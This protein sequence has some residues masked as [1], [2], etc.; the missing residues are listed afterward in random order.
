MTYLPIYLS[1]YHNFAFFSHQNWHELSSAIFSHDQF[2]FDQYQIKKH[3][4]LGF[5]RANFFIYLFLGGGTVEITGNLTKI[6][7]FI[8]FQEVNLNEWVLFS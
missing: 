8:K 5:T 4:W 3:T 2:K 6:Y 1:V 7:S